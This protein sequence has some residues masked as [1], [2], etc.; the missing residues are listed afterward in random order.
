MA[1]SFFSSVPLTQL[2]RLVGLDAHEHGV[3]ACEAAVARLLSQGVL[4]TD[5]CWIDQVTQAVYLDAPDGEADREAR[6]SACLQAL[7]AAHARLSA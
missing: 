2:T 3:Q 6:I 7:D 5:T 1:L 4:S